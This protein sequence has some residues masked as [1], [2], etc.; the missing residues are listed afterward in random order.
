MKY[1]I[2]VSLAVIALIVSPAVGVVRDV[3]SEY[4]TIQQAID[5][6]ND[7]DTVIVHPG[8]YYERI[9]FNGKNIVVTSTD[10]ND[11]R[12]V[13]YTI[14][15]GDG[16]GSVVTFESGETNAAVL[17]GFTITGGTGTVTSTYEDITYSYTDTSG[18]GIFCR[19]GSPTITRNVITNNVAPYSE[20]EVEVDLGG[21]RRTTGWHYEWSNGGGIYCSGGALVT[22]NVIYNNSA[23]MG[24]GIYA[25]NLCTVADN[26]IYDN[27]GRSGGG[28]YIYSGVLLNNTIVGNN[29]DLDPEWGRG[30]NVC[31]SFGYDP[32]S[33]TLA[34]NLICNARSGAGIYYSNGGGDAIRF[35]NV[36]GNTPSDY[37]MQDPRTYDLIFGDEVSWTGRYGNISQDPIFLNSWSQRYHLDPTSPCVSAGDPNFVPRP[38]ET[39]IDGD[40][41]V[42]AL[43]VDIGADEHVGYVKPLANAGDDHHILA[44]EPV[45]L[46][47]TDSYF[48]DPAGPTT[49]Q[50]TQTLGTEVQLDDPTAA[51]P[52]FTPSGEGWYKF[53]LVVADGQYTS[54]PDTVLVVVGNERPVANA[55]AD[56]LWEA[57]GGVQLNGS[58]SSDADPPD[59]LTYTWTQLGGPPVELLFLGDTAM[60]YFLSDEPGIYTFQLTVN[61]G[62]VDSEPDIV[63]VEGAPFTIEDR[64][65]C[66][67]GRR[68]LLLSRRYR[69]RRWLTWATKTTTVPDGRFAAPTS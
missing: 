49:F 23:E 12:I 65:L 14:L 63:K 32:T 53:D 18:A 60:P 7:G 51:Q 40:P 45:T 19:W 46:D 3:P 15:N 54:G 42:F 5:D 44:P 61:D 24:G 31:A 27:S 62:F 47:G 34:N 59:E 11:S 58:K 10:P 64:S 26:L 36:W 21:G 48:S 29:T 43:R 20:E 2:A 9:N 8:L 30:G 28:V 4:G 37:G 25:S 69:V 66:C 17:T 16:E 41:R 55:G 52:I 39:D 33:L 22:H 38:G 67:F 57:P 13:G 68:I 1:S 6:S 56:Q 35:N 50:W